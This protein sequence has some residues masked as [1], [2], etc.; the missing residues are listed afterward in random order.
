MRIFLFKIPDFLINYDNYLNYEDLKNLN[1]YPN[2]IFKKKVYGL[3]LQKFILKLN[4]KLTTTKII[5]KRDGYN[6]PYYNNE[7]NYNLSYSKDYIIIA[8]SKYQIGIDIEDEKDIK[9][10]LKKYGGQ[11][12][13][14]N[15]VSTNIKIWTKIESYLKFLGLG[16]FKIDDIKILNNNEI[17]DINNKNIFYQY[18]I[19]DKLPDKI[20]GTLT[21]Y[22]KINC[23]FFY[24]INL[25]ILINVLK[26]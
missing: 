3:L 25:N 18:D 5:L 21:T 7:I 24:N 9:K 8:Y 12:I 4:Y 22:K 6:K 1:N 26:N 17:I 10:V 19:S 2:N 20:Y 14:N 23:I 13:F 15:S 16:L 11:N